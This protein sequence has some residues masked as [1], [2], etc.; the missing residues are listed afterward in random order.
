M[1][2][3]LLGLVKMLTQNKSIGARFLN[4]DLIDVSTPNCKKRHLIG[5]M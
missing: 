5:R 2:S 4:L 3:M 1:N